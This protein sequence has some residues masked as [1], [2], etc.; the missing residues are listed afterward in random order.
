[1]NMRPAIQ[2]LPVTMPKGAI[3]Y[4]SHVGEL[5]LPTLPPAGCPHRPC[6]SRLSLRVATLD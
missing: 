2:S 5:D 1:M 3:I 6:F 4:S